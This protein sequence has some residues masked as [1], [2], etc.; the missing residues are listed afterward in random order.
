MLSPRLALLF[1]LASALSAAAGT[2]DFNYDIRPIISAKCYHCHGPDAASRKAKLR[3][4]IRD[5]ALKER[6]GIRSIV[7]G[8]LKASEL[9]LRIQSHDADEIMPPPKEGEPLTAR[10]ID[11]LTRWVQEGAEYK[12]HWAWTA[13]KPPASP[14]ASIDSFIAAR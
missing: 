4:D 6:D 10:E 11:L 2:V 7:P 12:E 9:V 3:L 5:E 13:P 1:L 14:N 8:D